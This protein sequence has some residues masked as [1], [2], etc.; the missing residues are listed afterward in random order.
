[1][2]G[3]FAKFAGAI[4]LFVAMVTLIVINSIGEVKK[5]ERC[6]SVRIKAYEKA[7]F[8]WNGI[9]ELNQKGQYQP[10]CL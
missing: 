2:E 5:L 3:N 6:K 7:Y 8:T 10:S 9:V 4:V 1:M